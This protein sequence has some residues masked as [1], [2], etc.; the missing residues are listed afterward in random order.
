MESGSKAENPE[1]T[2]QLWLHA[3]HKLADLQDF[4]VRRCKDRDR[5]GSGSVQEE[6]GF[7]RRLLKNLIEGVRS[8][9]QSLKRQHISVA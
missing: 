7:L 1:W 8:T 3:G 2:M 5:T 6:H 4:R 9:P